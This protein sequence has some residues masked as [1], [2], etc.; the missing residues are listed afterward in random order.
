MNKFII[1]VILSTV[2]ISGCAL[3]EKGARELLGTSTSSVEASRPEAIK[4]IFN[5]DFD[6]CYEKSLVSLKDINTFL[7]AKDKK[8]KMIAVFVSEQD[9]TPVGVFFKV[10]DADNTQV[11]VSSPST[12]ARDLIGLRL[13]AKL[14]MYLNPIEENSTAPQ[15]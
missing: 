9:T 11:E 7:F 3:L 4:Q 14:T 15:Q 5:F 12:Y 1:T 2:F 8:N 13:F 10:I 6:T